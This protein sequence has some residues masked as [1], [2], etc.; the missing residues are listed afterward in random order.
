MASKPKVSA[1]TEPRTY[2]LTANER[3]AAL[4]AEITNKQSE[5]K[6]EAAQRRAQRAAEAGGTAEA[7]GK[8]KGK[9]NTPDVSAS[10]KPAGARQSHPG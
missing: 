1:S 7:K 8:G 5:L 4:L 2:R 6:R 3:R 10:G 9:G